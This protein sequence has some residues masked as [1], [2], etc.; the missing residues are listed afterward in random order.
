MR[1]DL[2][3]GSGVGETQAAK[4]ELRQESTARVGGDRSAPAEFEISVGA[5]TNKALQ[6]PEV[7]DA[8][9]QELKAQIGAGNYRV[10]AHD[11]AGS[12]LDHMRVV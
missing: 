11:L 5:L 6:V 8:K 4:S 12:L 2:T 7:R 9:V 1:I 10:S 3:P